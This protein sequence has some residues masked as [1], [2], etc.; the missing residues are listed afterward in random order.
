MSTDA[1]V[2]SFCDTPLCS[3]V[4]T[5]PRKVK[6]NFLGAC[7]SPLETRKDNFNYSPEEW[8]LSGSMGYSQPLKTKP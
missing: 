5:A 4:L 6:S 7:Y 2:R 1:F 3:F 8:R